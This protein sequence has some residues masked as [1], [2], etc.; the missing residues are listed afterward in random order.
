[1]FDEGDWPLACRE[2]LNQKQAKLFCS[3]NC[4]V[5]NLAQHRLAKHGV[6]TESGEVESLVQPAGD[7][8]TSTLERENPRMLFEWAE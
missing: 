1:M 3:W 8:V 5:Q 4:A 2:C 6:K 7:L